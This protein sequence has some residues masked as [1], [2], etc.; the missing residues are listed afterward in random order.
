MLNDV[1]KIFCV[2][3]G[4][5]IVTQNKWPRELTQFLLFFMTVYV[6]LTSRC[7]S[8]SKIAERQVYT[9]CPKQEECYI[10]ASAVCAPS[11]L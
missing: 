9:T 6:L 5:S 1:E 8:H 2:D 7:F 10:D 11:R 4:A 3:L